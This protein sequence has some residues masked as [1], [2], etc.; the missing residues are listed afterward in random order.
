MNRDCNEG[1]RLR[2]RFEDELRKWGWFAACEKAVEIMPLGHE[3]IRE[4]QIQVWDAESMLF[5]ARSAYAEH[6]AHCLVCSRRLITPDAVSTIHE[7]LKKESEDANEG[8]VRQSLGGM[9]T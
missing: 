9:E 8:T 1:F 3:K 4:F 2:R 7:K 5:K 6:M